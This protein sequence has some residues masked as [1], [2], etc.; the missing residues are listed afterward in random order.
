MPGQLVTVSSRGRPRVQAPGLKQI[1]QQPKHPSE[2]LN[3]KAAIVALYPFNIAYIFQTELPMTRS[4]EQ[5]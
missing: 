2:E 3:M 5:R 4:Q 1:Q